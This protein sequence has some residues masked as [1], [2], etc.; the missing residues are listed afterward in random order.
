M[1]NEGIDYEDYIQKEDG[2]NREG[3]QRWWVRRWRKGELKDYGVDYENRI[4]K[5]DENSCWI[6]L[7]KDEVITEKKEEYN[8]EIHEDIDYTNFIEEGNDDEVKDDKNNA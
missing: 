8:D 2:S 7:F 1:K 6:D 5:E 4:Q 3:W